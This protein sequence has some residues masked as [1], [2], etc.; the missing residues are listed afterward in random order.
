M[1][2]DAKCKYVDNIIDETVNACSMKDIYVMLGQVEHDTGYSVDFLWSV[3]EELLD[4]NDDWKNAWH[5][6]IEQAI[7]VA[8]EFDY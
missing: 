2:S 8:Y 7:V 4:A 1:W 6:S 3:I 5:E